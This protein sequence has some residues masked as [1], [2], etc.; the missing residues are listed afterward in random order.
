M[1]IV[2]ATV[3]AWKSLH[4]S[5]DVEAG[6]A[7]TLSPSNA[8]KLLLATNLFKHGQRTAFTE[9]RPHARV[10]PFW[11]ASTNLPFLSVL[12]LQTLQHLG[13]THY[14]EVHA[15]HMKCTSKSLFNKNMVQD[16]IFWEGRGRNCSLS[17]SVWFPLRNRWPHFTLVTLL[18]ISFTFPCDSYLN[19]PSFFS[20]CHFTQF[21]RG[22]GGR[23]RRQLPSA[24]NKAS[25]HWPSTSLVTWSLSSSLQEHQFLSSIPSV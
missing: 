18:L 21:K 7:I 24:R 10:R 3:W 12:V 11:W 1:T 22:G 15:S 20:P 9:Q 2:T 8:D 17:H 5:S 19:L 13:Q 6:R 16:E 4:R 25:Q 14:R 23:E